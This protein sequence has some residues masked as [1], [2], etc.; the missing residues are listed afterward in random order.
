MRN[1][2]NQIPKF[3][4]PFLHL[5]LFLCT[6]I[7]LS[8]YI[9]TQKWLGDAAIN[10]QSAHWYIWSIFCHEFCQFFLQSQRNHL[11]NR[12]R[13]IIASFRYLMRTS[14][15]E[16]RKE[17]VRRE[18]FLLFGRVSLRNRGGVSPCNE[19]LE[20]DR[21]LVPKFQSFF[22][23]LLEN[24]KNPFLFLYYS[25]KI[26][27]SQIFDSRQIFS[28]PYLSASRTFVVDPSDA[29]NSIL[30]NMQQKRGTIFL[31]RSLFEFQ[32]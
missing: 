26:M 1:I 8:M 10:C 5:C 18:Y 13:N 2:E 14:Y 21:G 15:Y 11:N 32:P 25:I 6:H 23:Y 24:F 9:L 30:Q 16:K 7:S 4:Q 12:R 3:A 20:P 29:A 22:K 17:I 31:K 19:R 28:Q 27:K